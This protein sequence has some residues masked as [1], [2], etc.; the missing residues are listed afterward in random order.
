[1]TCSASDK[2]G[3]IATQSFNVTVRYN[4]VGITVS[5]GNKKAGSTVPVSFQLTGGSASVTN[6]VAKLTYATLTGNTPGLALPASAP[7][8]SNT[9]NLFR[10]DAA[11][12]QYLYNWST[13]G[14]SAGTYRLTVDLGDGV[15]HHV[16][17]T[18]N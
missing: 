1:V 7:G 9:G 10:Y 11:T 2:A 4:T 14:L 13:K 6:A 17:V 5:N 12:H 15:D 8:N 18:L 16:D 3:N